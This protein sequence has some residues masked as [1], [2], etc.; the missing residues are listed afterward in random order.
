VPSD[1]TCL[2]PSA[3]RRQT[4]EAD[5]QAGIIRLLNTITRAAA[6]GENSDQLASEGI[7]AL[8]DARRV[9]IR[10]GDP[11]NEVVVADIGE[12]GAPLEVANL[13]QLDAEGHI[14]DVRLRPPTG[15]VVRWVRP[16][17]GVVLQLVQHRRP[18]GRLIVTFRQGRWI[19][20][21]IRLA[22]ATIAHALATTTGPAVSHD[23]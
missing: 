16:S 1:E 17:Q 13:A 18:V 23:Q 11:D 15:P 20:L 8:L 14:L 22:L 5:T 3:R 9:V 21:V 12:P 4:V 7:Y 6:T 10:R 2:D 19:P